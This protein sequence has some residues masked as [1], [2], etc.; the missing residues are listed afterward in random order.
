MDV[1]Q[2]SSAICV[3]TS[4]G[5]IDQETKVATTPAGLGEFFGG[6][7]TMRVYIEAGGQ[8]D[9]VARQLEGMGH[10]PR[11]IDPGQARAIGWSKL[12][13]DKVDARLL[14]D[15]GRADLL[16]QVHR[17]RAES[18]AL[19]RLLVTRAGLVRIRAGLCRQ[20]RAVLRQDGVILPRVP[21]PD[22]PLHL[23]TQGSCPEDLATVIDPLIAV[24][25]EVTRQIDLI[26]KQLHGIADADPTIRRQVGIPGVG[27]IVALTYCA[28]LDTPRRF[29]DGRR[30]ASYIGLVPSEN[31]SGGKQRLGAITKRGNRDVRWLLVQA[32]H[33][34]MR[35]KQ[36]TAL[37][38]WGL[39]IAARKGKRKAAVAVAR[40]LAVVMWTLWKDEVDYIPFHGSTRRR[41]GARQ[42]AIGSTRRRRRA[43]HPRKAAE[44]RAHRGRSAGRA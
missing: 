24:M 41:R 21:T 32:A 11:V 38:R 30:V 7:A 6:R 10:D 42:P 31:S 19:R 25:E 23:R 35:S 9:W 40:K 4:R 13:N 22:L 8:S 18:E 34:L 15:L 20:V 2:E 1:A 16:V 44:K 14:A 33:A 37:R 17:R 28:L 3:M 39:A 5:R 26:E 36:D 12:K 29:P 43:V 27:P